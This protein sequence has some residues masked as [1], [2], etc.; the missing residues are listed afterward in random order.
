MKA[1]KDQVLQSNNITVDSVLTVIEIEGMNIRVPNITPYIELICENQIIETHSQPWDQTQCLKSV[2]RLE[3][4]LE[5]YGISFREKV[6][7][8]FIIFI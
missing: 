1:K 4:N 3:C 2:L 5:I 6:P 7:Y 8:K